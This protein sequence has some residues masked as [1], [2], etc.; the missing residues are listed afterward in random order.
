MPT[1]EKINKVDELTAAMAGAKAIYLADF[2]GIDVAKVTGL[3]NQ[4]RE[5]GIGYQVVKNRLAKRAAEAAGIEGFSEHFVGPTAI[6]YS[7]DDPIAP[8]KILQDFAEKDDTFSIKTGIMDGKILTADEVVV[9][10]KLPSRDELL[11]KVVGSIQSPLY[12][13]AVV[14]NGLLRNLVGVV[15]AIEEKQRTDSGE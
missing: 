9:L 12:G 5:A 4:L 6:A 11:G 1:S 15:S 8:A 2:T 13:F 10:A 14:L 7:N 3:R